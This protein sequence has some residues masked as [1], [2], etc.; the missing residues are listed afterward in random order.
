VADLLLAGCLLYVLFFYYL[1]QVTNP[2]KPNSEPGA[3]KIDVDF[4]RVIWHESFSIFLHKLTKI[5]HLGEWVIDG[6]GKKLHLFP[7]IWILSAD[8][9]EQ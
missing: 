5:T 7:F 4:K 3:T 6:N 8:F 1:L 9:E 2:L